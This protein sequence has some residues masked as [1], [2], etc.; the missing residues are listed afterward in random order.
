[1]HAYEHTHTHMHSL[2]L[3]LCSVL[4]IQIRL[5]EPHSVSVF[6]DSAVASVNV[7]GNDVRPAGWLVMHLERAAGNWGSIIL[8]LFTEIYKCI[9][10]RVKN[11]EQESKRERLSESENLR[12]ANADIYFL[13]NHFHTCLWNGKAPWKRWG[14]LQY[15]EQQPRDERSSSF[16]VTF[17][18]RSI[19][20]SGIRWQGWCLLLPPPSDWGQSRLPRENVIVSLVERGPMVSITSLCLSLM[21]TAVGNGSNTNLSHL[22]NKAGPTGPCLASLPA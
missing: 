18:P 19:Y 21:K 10:E 2:S 11:K 8:T 6:W 3:S 15:Y 9:H 7:S 1:M 12:T 5:F 22:F 17:S 14:K 16:P 4:F 13:V 20:W